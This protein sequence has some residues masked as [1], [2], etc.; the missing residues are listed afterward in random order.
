MI[1][2]WQNIISNEE[3]YQIMHLIILIFVTVCWAYQPQ[4]PRYVW[5]N[6]SHN[7]SFIKP[8]YYNVTYNFTNYPNVSYIP[9]GISP[10]GLPSNPNALVYFVVV[11]VICT[12]MDYIN[13][14]FFRARE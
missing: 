9:I 3:N 11:L 1:I 5:F 4:C 6:A 8:E 7:I 14:R 13:V 2:F 10:Q 12:F